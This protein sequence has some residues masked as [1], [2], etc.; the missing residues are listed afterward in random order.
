MGTLVVGR[1]LDWMILEVYSNL[2]D[3]ITDNAE[4]QVSSAWDMPSI[5]A[6]SFV[7]LLWMLSSTSIS[8]LYCGAQNCN[9]YSKQVHT[10]AKYSRRITIL[11]H[12]AA[13]CLMHPTMQFALL[14]ARAHH[15]PLLSCWHQHLQ[16]LSC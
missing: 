9:E 7:A 15:W 14:A 11:Y 3:S 8:C 2:N 16:V 4:T 12:L 1:Q 6:T 5:L 13:L 10:N